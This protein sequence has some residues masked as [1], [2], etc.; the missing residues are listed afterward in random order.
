MLRAGPDG[1]DHELQQDP[2]A[3]WCA[4]R[5]GLAQ[6]CEQLDRLA[7]DMA[8]C[9]EDAY[10]EA[11]VT[12]AVRGRVAAEATCGLW[13]LGRFRLDDGGGRVDPRDGAEGGEVLLGAIQRC[14]G[15]S[16]R[17]A[18]TGCSSSTL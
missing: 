13:R 18:A 5:C 7:T 17:A 15:R 4:G 12:R 14:E 2:V 3:R 6:N 8:H 9:L 11:R 16:R 10:D 1:D